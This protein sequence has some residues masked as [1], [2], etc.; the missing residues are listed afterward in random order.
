MASRAAVGAFVDDRTDQDGRVSQNALKNFARLAN[1][2]REPYMKALQ[3][4]LNFNMRHSLRIGG[5]STTG[6]PWMA[7]GTSERQSLHCS[8]RTQGG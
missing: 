4:E 1:F 3:V 2:D 5:W 7:P 6:P 8:L